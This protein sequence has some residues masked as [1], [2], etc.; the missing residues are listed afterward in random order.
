MKENYNDICN[1]VEFA[2]EYNF[3]RIL[4][5]FV[6]GEK[7]KEFSYDDKK[8]ILFLIDKAKRKAEQY[9]LDLNL[10]GVINLSEDKFEHK[11]SEQKTFDDKLLYCRLPWRKITFNTHYNFSPD[12]QCKKS[13]SFKDKSV[14]ECW[15][16]NLM[17]EYRKKILDKSFNDICKKNCSLR[18]I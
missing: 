17:Q 9:K 18:N 13:E 2:H 3:N 1:I 14:L 10:D 6:R 11:K 4:F 12:C 15:N 16:S 5:I 8:T 7:E